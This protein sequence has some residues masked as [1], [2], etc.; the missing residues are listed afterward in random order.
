M[1]TTGST[2]P[3]QGTETPNKLAFPPLSPPPGHGELV[4][5]YPLAGDASGALAE[6]EYTYEQ[7]ENRQ[8]ELGVS[9]WNSTVTMRANISVEEDLTLRYGLRGGFDYELHR[10]GEGEGLVWSLPLLGS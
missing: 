9:A 4:T 10:L 5:R 7:G 1:R 6:Y 3:Q 2:D 8:L